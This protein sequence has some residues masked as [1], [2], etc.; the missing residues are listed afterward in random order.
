MLYLW[1]GI[2][3]AKNYCPM[4]AL[5]SEATSHPAQSESEGG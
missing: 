2:E 4:Q 1:A 5:G 3:Y